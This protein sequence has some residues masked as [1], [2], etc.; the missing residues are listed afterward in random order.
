MRIDK[1]RDLILMLADKHQTAVPT[2][3]ELDAL[4]HQAQLF[5]FREY[6][7]VYEETQVIHTALN[8]FRMSSGFTT[9]N[10]EY[11]FPAD[12]EYVTGIVAHISSPNSANRRA[13]KV[14][15]ED[16]LGDAL[17][18]SVRP[19]SIDWPIAVITGGKLRF[20]PDGTHAG[21]IFWLRTPIEPK[22]NYTQSG[23]Q[24]MYNQVGSVDLEW[25]DAYVADVVLKTL[26]L[27]GISLNSREI[28]AASKTFNQ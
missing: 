6:F 1:T 24:V 13:V 20:Y 9:T 11:H 8:P 28:Q 4:L 10:N 2:P 15:K 14:Y 18:S 25:A 23:R 5:V 22:F 26:E 3:E 12:L 27:L 21:S 17:A 7:K 19:V 16:E